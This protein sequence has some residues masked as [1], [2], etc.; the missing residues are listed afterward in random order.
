MFCICI[1]LNGDMEHMGRMINTR[2]PFARTLGLYTLALLGHALQQ[3]ATAS[4]F[5]PASSLTNSAN[6][7]GTDATISQR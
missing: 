1:S 3:I 5:P 7:R 2:W 4:C 6:S